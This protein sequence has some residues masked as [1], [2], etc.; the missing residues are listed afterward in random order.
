MLVER[1]VLNNLHGVSFDYPAGWQE[2]SYTGT[3]VGSASA[4]WTTAVGPGTPH[5]AIFVGPTG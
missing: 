4:L 5:D 3:S 1:G 2:G